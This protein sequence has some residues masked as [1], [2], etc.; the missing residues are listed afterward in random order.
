MNATQLLEMQHDEAK[1]ILESLKRADVPARQR[2]VAELSAALRGHATIEEERLYP[3]L[4]EKAETHEL[5]RESWRE[6]EEMKIALG[7]LERCAVEDIEFIDLVE[8]LEKVVLHHVEEEEGELFPKIEDLFSADFLDRLG[9]EM[10][11]RYESLQSREL[12][13]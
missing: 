6:H 13:T 10:E 3:R 7:D 4:E 12:R 2:L 11:E 5:I 9:D 8:R 1:T